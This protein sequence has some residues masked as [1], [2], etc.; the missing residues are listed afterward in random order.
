MPAAQVF[1]TRME[2]L[3][4]VHDSF[5]A[6]GRA[7]QASALSIS[8]RTYQCAKACGVS[9]FWQA[10]ARITSGITAHGVEQHGSFCSTRTRLATRAS[11]VHAL[12]VGRS[13]SGFCAA[14]TASRHAGTE[15]HSTR[16]AARRTSHA[17]DEG[18]RQTG[19][20]SVAFMTPIPRT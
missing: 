3:K 1:H 8:C 2:T 20:C 9:S 4:Q 16:S 5:E 12:A 6:Q 17:E 7:G 13:V 19:R 18:A 10:E 11:F 15:S 14:D